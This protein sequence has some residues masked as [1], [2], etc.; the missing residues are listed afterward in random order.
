[1][2]CVGSNKIPLLKD[3]LNESFIYAQKKDHA[4]TK[5]FAKHE[6]F[7]SWDRVSCK[8]PRSFE[9]VILD[10]NKA[11]GIYDDVIKFMNN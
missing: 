2:W 5:I 4:K 11:Q 10:T 3:F 7:N 9:S 1:M 8:E 6:W